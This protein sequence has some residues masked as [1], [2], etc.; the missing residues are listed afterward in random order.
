[1]T[2]LHHTA[3]LYIVQVF[4]LNSYRRMEA[5]KQVNKSLTDLQEVTH[6]QIHWK[7][8]AIITM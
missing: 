4:P 2:I 5:I 1:M 7:I 6:G 3:I 8:E